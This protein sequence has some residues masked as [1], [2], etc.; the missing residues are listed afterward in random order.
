MLMNHKNL[1]EGLYLEGL[2][3]EYFLGLLTDGPLIVILYFR[4]SSCTCI[5][6]TQC[7]S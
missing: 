2:K 5:L 7:C 6:Y 3:L 1:K 4:S